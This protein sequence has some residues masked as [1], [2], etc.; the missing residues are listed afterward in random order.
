MKL[1]MAD[2]LGS[3]AL[4]EMSLFHALS[5]GKGSTPLRLAPAPTDIALHAEVLVEPVE[6]PLPVPV[7]LPPLP[8]PPPVLVPPPPVL[9]PPPVD[10]PPADAV[11]PQP[12]MMSRSE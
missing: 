3:T 12:V 8:E 5:A 4:A 1:M 7:P 6:P 9:V 11:P 2:E 10:E